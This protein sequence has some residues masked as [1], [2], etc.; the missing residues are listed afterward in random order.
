MAIHTPSARVG[1]TI[2]TADN[3]LRIVHSLGRAA[4]IGDPST[5]DSPG[6]E[7]ANQEGQTSLLTRATNV[8][9]TVMDIVER[10]P[11][12]ANALVSNN[13]QGQREY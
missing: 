1:E 6:S 9:A 4:V 2:G 10:F 5:V 3:R 11:L 13:P 7:T 12:G 8:V